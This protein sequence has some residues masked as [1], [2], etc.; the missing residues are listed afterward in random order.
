MKRSSSVRQSVDFPKTEKL[1]TEVKE[2]E[3]K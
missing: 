1:D 3:I 2:Q